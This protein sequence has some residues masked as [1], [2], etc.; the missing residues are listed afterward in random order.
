MSNPEGNTY[1]K[2]EEQTTA[3]TATPWR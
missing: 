3:P 1:D 2:V